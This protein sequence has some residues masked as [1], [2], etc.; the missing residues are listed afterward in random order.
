MRQ[1]P[2]GEPA[3]TAALNFGTPRRRSSLKRLCP[4]CH[5]RQRY[6][7]NLRRIHASRFVSTRGVW[8]KTKYPRHPVRDGV[9]SS[10]NSGSVTPRVPRAVPLCLILFFSRGFV[11]VPPHPPSLEILKPPHLRPF[12]A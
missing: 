1:N 11:L 3:A 12:E 5:C 7:R 8:Q 4:F 9:P 10:I 2:V 6:A